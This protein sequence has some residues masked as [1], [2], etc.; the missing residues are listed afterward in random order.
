MINLFANKKTKESYWGGIGN[1]PKQQ[2]MI[3]KIITGWGV[4]TIVN[5]P[6]DYINASK[7]FYEYPTLVINA[8]IT[9][10][11]R[12]YTNEEIDSIKK[13]SGITNII[14]D[15][16]NGLINKGVSKAEVRIS[17]NGVPIMSYYPNRN[18]LASFI[19]IFRVNNQKEQV[20]SMVITE[21][22]NRLM[23]KHNVH[24][25]KLPIIALKRRLFVEE[26]MQRR[27]VNIRVAKE[28]LHDYAT[29]MR[30]S[31][32]NFIKYKN[33]LVDS[34]QL[35][36]S[37]EAFGKY[38]FSDFDKAIKRINQ[39]KFVKE[40]KFKGNKIVVE[41]GKICISG[42][43]GDKNYD[44]YVGDFS[45]EITPL[46]ISVHNKHIPSNMGYH[47][48]NVNHNGQWCQGDVRKKASELS[49]TL[50][51]KELIY[52]TYVMMNKYNDRDRDVSISDWADAREEEDIYDSKGRVIKKKREIQQQIRI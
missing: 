36:K 44:V 17:D 14:A 26:F 1:F 6:Y 12:T 20:V 27:D 11:R 40:V 49:S 5:H 45:F 33:L 16:S 39:L 41:V 30:N 32:E 3:N 43:Q 9:Q 24:L 35:I 22:L 31:Q 15:H 46:G 4:K 25:R 28:S 48:F 10:F 21:Y 38:K 51:F 52:I 47:H 2:I 42:M 34:R 29:D 19:S 50:K 7:F 8:N 18:I 37:L 13:A 23:L